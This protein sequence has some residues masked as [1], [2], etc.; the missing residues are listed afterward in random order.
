M[1]IIKLRHTKRKKKTTIPRKNRSSRCHYPHHLAFAGIAHYRP[2][3]RE[4]IKFIKKDYIRV[5]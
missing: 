4:K 2:N 1:I 3:G 5:V